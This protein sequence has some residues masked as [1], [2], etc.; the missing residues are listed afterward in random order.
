MS[1]FG[2]S[3]DETNQANPAENKHTTSP[4][5]SYAHAEGGGSPS[6]RS[7]SMRPEFHD[8]LH[9]EHPDCSVSFYLGGRHHC[10]AC[11][12]TLCSSH[13]SLQVLLPSFGYSTETAETICEECYERYSPDEIKNA[14]ATFIASVYRRHR[15]QQRIL[16]LAE[17]TAGGLVVPVAPGADDSDNN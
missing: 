4:S 10:R 11:G 5:P 15:V 14:A 13:G 7:F 2:A 3:E 1:M 8:A 16:F 17:R 6:K 9:C 12:K